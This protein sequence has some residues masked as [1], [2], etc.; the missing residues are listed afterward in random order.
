MRN[1]ENCLISNLK[2]N[3]RWPFYI[4][5]VNIKRIWD[6]ERNCERHDEIENI[7]HFYW[8]LKQR[9]IRFGVLNFKSKIWLHGSP[10]YNKSLS[11]C[12]SGLVKLKIMSYKLNTYASNM[13]ATT[14]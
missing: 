5:S 4:P 9:I 1:K 8:K 10:K 13:K 7:D 2:R 6:C 12:S 14:L 11:K 3:I